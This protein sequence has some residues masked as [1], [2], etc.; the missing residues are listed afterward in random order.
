[1]KKEKKDKIVMAVTIGI[2]CFALVMIM[3]MQ[4]KVINQTDITS[5][6]T[7]RESELRTELSNWKNRYEEINE[8][9]QEVQQ[10]TAE[11][12]EK[13]ESNN[14]TYSLLKTELDQ[15]NLALGKTDVEGAGIIIT[16]KDNPNADTDVNADDLLTI[17]NSLK[18]AGAE[19]I[20]VNDERIVNM[21]DIVYISNGS[22]VKINGQRIL[23]PYIIK[24]IGDPT[25][26]ESSLVGNG[27]HLDDL[28]NREHEVIV[29]QE[30]EVT[31]SKYN[32][33]M[34]TKYIK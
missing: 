2:S 33:E 12:K 24:A 20:S 10:R 21:S 25:Y 27:G 29:E 6:E 34:T 31:I 32:D 13:T 26:L 8:K 1:M 23:S 28:K 14:E 17:V 4:F 9:Y 11:Y 19:A 30:R 5:I 18:L 15:T 22:F 16:I 3:F 7:M